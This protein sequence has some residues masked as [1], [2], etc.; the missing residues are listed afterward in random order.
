V[1]DFTTGLWSRIGPENPKTADY[2]SQLDMSFF[3]Y[4][5]G[6]SYV[7]PALHSYNYPAYVPPNVSGTGARGSWLIPQLIGGAGSGAF[8]HAVNLATGEWSRFSTNR[9][10]TGQSPYAGSFEDTRRQRLWWASMDASSMNMLDWKEQ[11]PR[12]IHSV[13]CLPQG[14]AFAFGGYYAR[15]V[16]V[17]EADMTIGF[18][19]YYGDTKLRGEVLDMSSGQ[20]AYFSGGNWPTMNLRGSG[21][22]V[23]WCPHT[24]AFYFYDGYGTTKIMKLSPST[25]EF[26][27]CTWTWSEEEITA[28][29]WEANPNDEFRGG[30]QA[31]SR[32]RYIPWLRCF[33]WCDGPNFSAPTADG[34]ARAGVMQLWRPRGT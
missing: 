27:E 32:W 10:V 20:P 23:D 12:A 14:S 4:L 22:G 19:C 21:F 1:F 29:A 25:L 7:V 31:M 3:D 6:S 24:K 33:A 2:T 9:G 34:V 28:P 18:W 8:P 5:L 17:A 30:A 16:Y 13:P 15:H 26:H 11:H